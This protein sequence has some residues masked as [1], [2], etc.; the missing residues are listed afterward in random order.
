MKAGDGVVAISDLSS[1]IMVGDTVEV[2]GPSEISETLDSDGALDGLPFM[3]EMLEYCGKRFKVIHKASRTCV[4]FMSRD[5]SLRMAQFAQDDVFFL[6][7]LRC[8]GIDHDGCGRG[9][10]IFWKSA[11]L[12][13]VDGTGDGEPVPGEDA[14]QLRRRLKV[15]CEESCYFCQST[16][17]S[18]ATGTITRAQ[19]VLK[20]YDDLCSGGCTGTE[21]VMA[22]AGPVV[23]KLAK[24]VKGASS[25]GN[26]SKVPGGALD[27]QPGELVEVRSF[28]E[29]E[30]T[31][32]SQGKHRGLAFVPD[33][34][35]YCGRRYRVLRRLD[36]MI[37]EHSGEMAEV[38]DT[39]LLE[40]NTC[41]FDHTFGG[42][43]RNE[44]NYWRE[45]WLRRVTE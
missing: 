18:K 27:L 43:P 40:E 21:A 12:R 6:E 14:E 4:A 16:Q 29:I 28:R 19:K 11:W 34:K 20:V 41:T 2:R 15:K 38:K 35:R 10:R 25:D 45:I 7:G 32:D 22:T 1:A 31:L 33:M 9:C 8:N 17:L 44:F 37:L 24:M 36:R 13:K 3:P 26:L 30:E 5:L 39:V 42:C 23:R